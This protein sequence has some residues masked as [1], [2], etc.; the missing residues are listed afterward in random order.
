MPISSLS[1][2]FYWTDK[3]FTGAEYLQMAKQQIKQKPNSTQISTVLNREMISGYKP[4]QAHWANLPDL[5]L[6]LGLR[7]CPKCY[8]R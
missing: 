3:N 4:C 5:S 6:L 7:R 1:V 8:D 2:V